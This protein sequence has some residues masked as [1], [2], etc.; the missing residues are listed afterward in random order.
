MS[1]LG[2]SPLSYMQSERR[3]GVLECDIERMSCALK[4][5]LKRNAIAE[6][7]PLKA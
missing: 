3:V 6:R 4:K 7:F 5:K 1:S 2:G